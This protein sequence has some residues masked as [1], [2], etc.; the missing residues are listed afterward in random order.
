M[1]K[2]VNSMTSKVLGPNS[3][4]VNLERRV[5]ASLVSGLLVKFGN[6]ELDLTGR[7]HLSKTLGSVLDQL[8]AES[9]SLEQEFVK[10]AQ[11]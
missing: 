3:K 5:D 8:I 7:T 6:F 10:I 4:G 2:Q 9:N 11:H 1:S